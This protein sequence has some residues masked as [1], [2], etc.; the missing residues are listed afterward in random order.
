MALCTD[1]EAG[2]P[3]FIRLILHLF[4]QNTY[5]HCIPATDVS[6]IAVDAAPFTDDDN[7][8]EVSHGKLTYSQPPHLMQNS[9]VISGVQTD[10][11]S[12]KKE[13]QSCQSIHRAC[14]LHAMH[15]VGNTAHA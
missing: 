14:V 5:M 9:D 12:Q 1:E 7:I 10:I 6:A 8:S 11:I 3:L 2:L 4:V 13:R 15:R